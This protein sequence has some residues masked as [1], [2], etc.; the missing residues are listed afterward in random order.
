VSLLLSFDRWWRAPAPAERLALLRILVGAYC[1]GLLLLRGLSILRL[2]QL[3]GARFD[4]VGLAALLDTPLSLPLLIALLVLAFVGATC[5]CVGARHRVLAPAFAVLLTFLLG[6]RNSWGHM[7]HSEQLVCVHVLLLSVLPAADALSLDHR[8]GRTRAGPSENY[9]APLRLLML[10][11]VISY[12]LAGWAKIHQ[13]GLAWVRGEAVYNQVAND[14]LSK[15]R[16]GAFVSPLGSTL[17]RWPGLFAGMSVFTLI[18][19]LGALLAMLGGRLRTA[20][21]V[22][23]Y[24]MH[25]GIA[26]AMG[27]AFPYPLWGIAFVSFFELEHAHAWLRATRR[28]VVRPRRR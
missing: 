5:F 17:L 15:L 6:Y 16:L 12:M 2:A 3:D 11:V 28:S 10:C 4:G 13:G 24:A 7:S 26:L 19:E 18:I 8:A 22:G 21:V 14:T 27:I 1:M 20:W 9:G 23:A 25:V